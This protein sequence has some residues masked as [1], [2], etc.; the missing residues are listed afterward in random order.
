MHSSGGTWT[1]VAV[2]GRQGSEDAKVQYL[3]TYYNKHPLLTPGSPSTGIRLSALL[4]A[5]PEGV[6]VLFPSFTPRPL[7]FLAVLWKQSAVCITRTY[8]P[9]PSRFYYYLCLPLLL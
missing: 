7:L 6:I 4:L 8:L 1:G 2:S 5:V 9:T 3:D